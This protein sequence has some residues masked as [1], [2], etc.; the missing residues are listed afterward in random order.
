MSFLP[1]LDEKGF[2]IKKKKQKRWAKK[3]IAKVR[4]KQNKKRRKHKNWQK[5]KPL[6]P[7][8]YR[9]YINSR[10]WSK[11]RRRYYARNPNTCKICGDKNVHLHH[12]T[13]KRLGMEEDEDLIPLCVEHHD[14]FHEFIG[15]SKGDMTDETVAFIEMY[16]YEEEV[17]L[18]MRSL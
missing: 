11:R 7:S 15:G 14:A 8:Q 10:R 18:M 16:R 5:G 12:I 9:D 13:Y 2:Y 6:K 17:N 4:G 1:A 3:F